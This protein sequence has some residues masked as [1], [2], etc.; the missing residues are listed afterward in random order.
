MKQLTIIFSLLLSTQILF[1]ANGDTNPQMDQNYVMFTKAKNGNQKILL[2]GDL[3]YFKTTDMVF[4]KR[5]YVTQI[6]EDNIV[7]SMEV[8]GKSKRGNFEIVEFDNLKTLYIKGDKKARNRVWLAP[9][10][11]VAPVFT[12]V[13]FTGVKSYRELASMRFDKEQWDSAP[14]IQN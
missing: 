5:A 8:F 6:N 11:L 13:T 7:L 2:I 1:A 3:I 4:Q 12:G 9:A 14:V 10:I